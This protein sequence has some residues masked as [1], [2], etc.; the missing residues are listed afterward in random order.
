MPLS[1]RLLISQPLSK[2]GLS[3]AIHGKLCSSLS[4]WCR[5]LSEF[6]FP[7]SSRLVRLAICISYDG[8][9]GSVIMFHSDDYISLF[10]SF[11]DIP[12][13]LGNLIQRIASVYD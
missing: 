7:S 4:L 11:F 1:H 13:R 3:G 6:D 9:L 12:V 8:L 2:S 5:A 10:M